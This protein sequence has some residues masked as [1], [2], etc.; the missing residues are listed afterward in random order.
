MEKMTER[1]YRE[2]YLDGRNTLDHFA[3]ELWGE[4]RRPPARRVGVPLALARRQLAPSLPDSVVSW[5]PLRTRTA[6][7][8]M[9]VLTLLDGLGRNREARILLLAAIRG[10]ITLPFGEVVQDLILLQALARMQ[11][12]ADHAREEGWSVSA[13]N[14]AGTIVLTTRAGRPDADPVRLDDPFE[15]VVW[16]H[17]AAGRVV[18]LYPQSP[19][20][21]GIALDEDGRHEFRTLAEAVRVDATVPRAT[22]KRALRCPPRP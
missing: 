10:K 15:R 12:R 21:A 18:P 6:R 16:D 8:A 4:A 2:L 7:R 9:L 3:E 19:D 11:E 5:S 13:E 22:L 20:R 14:A 17:S 1:A